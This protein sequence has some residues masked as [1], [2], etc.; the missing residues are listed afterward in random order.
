MRVG[1]GKVIIELYGPYIKRSLI[2][3][4]FYLL[5]LDDHMVL[6]TSKSQRCGKIYF[7]L[8]W[9]WVLSKMR[10][11]K[12]NY[13]VNQAMPV[14]I[15][16]SYRDLLASLHNFSPFSIKIYTYIYMILGIA[17]GQCPPPLPK[18]NFVFGDLNMHNF[19]PCFS[20]NLYRYMNFLGGAK[21]YYSPHSKYWGSS[22]LPP[23]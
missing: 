4:T 3:R 10:L 20:L 19:R 7:P 11:W 22:A 2:L 23:S 17:R 5:F 1:D 12:I 13:C 8:F 16:L 9:W 21:G 15:S 18:K 14:S 6:G